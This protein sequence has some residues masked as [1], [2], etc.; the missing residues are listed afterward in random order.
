MVVVGSLVH[1]KLKMA[2]LL[3][4]GASGGIGQ[5]LC[6]HLS[7]RHEVIPL[8]RSPPDDSLF[9]PSDLIAEPPLLRGHVDSQKAGNIDWI[10]HL[11]TTYDINDDLAMLDNLVDFAQQHQIKN[12]LYVSSWVVHFPRR[13][14][15]ASYIEMKRQCEQRLLQSGISKVRIIRPSVVV[16]PGLSWTKILK[17]LAP[18]TAIIPAGFSRSFVTI[19]EVNSCIEKVIS[20]QSKSVVVT[21]LGNRISLAAKAREYRSPKTQ[22]ISWSIS[23]AIVVTILSGVFLAGPQQLNSTILILGGCLSVA[24]VL[25]QALP[26]LLGS[27][28]DYFAGFVERRFDPESEPDLIALC[29]RDNDNIQVR[30]YD[31]ASL[32]F[33]Q[34]NSPRHTTICL[35][36]FNQVLNLDR[37]RNLISVQAGAHF[38]DLLPLLESHG[39]WLDNYPNY[40]FI[41]IGAC[42]VTPV[43]GS[44]LNKPFLA[45]LVE[46]IRYYD[47]DAD[48]LV[49]VHCQDDGFSKLIF[50]QVGSRNR[51]ILSAKL[52][53]S[54]RQYYELTTRRQPVQSLCFDDE[55]N[56]SDETQHYEVRINSPASRDALLQSYRQVPCENAEMD[57]GL[58]AI[59]AD[60]IGRKWNLLQRNGLLSFVTSAASRF[61]INFEWFFTPEEFSR[62]WAEVS[63]DRRRNRLYKLLVRYNPSQADL[64]T[65][66][67]GTVSID[68]TIFNTRSMLE[69]SADLYERYRPLE[70]LGKYSIERYIKQCKERRSVSIQSA[71]QDQRSLQASV[72]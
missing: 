54:P 8:S 35:R 17:R 45:D 61:F 30:G 69:V 42:V 3:I 57:N 4:T 64:N 5:H 14:L 53:T 19:D 36:R 34:P 59:K 47:R 32:Y 49:E 38:G 39:L 65:S 40:H 27:V 1:E 48:K 67:H 29:H 46:S 62:F 43:H 41:S 33:Q 52:R 9:G 22:L 50:S 60:S 55:A 12:F 66:Y 58:L 25:R 20:D 10:I 13:R 16:G 28:S 72:D 68:V 2:N 56:F 18:F 26:T 51:I 71:R 63:S 24:W 44:N 21:C 15:A 37:D 31:N 70:H 6:Q 11:A 7:T 23:V